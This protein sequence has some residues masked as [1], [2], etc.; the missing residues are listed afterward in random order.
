MLKKA[1]YLYV[2]SVMTLKRIY[3]E[4]VVEWARAEAKADLARVTQERE[5]AYQADKAKRENEQ[6]AKSGSSAQ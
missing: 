2:K 1:M 4:A 5:A 6:A 3:D